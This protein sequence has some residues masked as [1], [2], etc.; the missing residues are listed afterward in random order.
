MR[1]ADNGK[2][3]PKDFFE[4][5]RISL[6][7]H[8]MKSLSEQIDGRMEILSTGGVIISVFFKS[9]LEEPALVFRKVEMMAENSLGMNG[10]NG[11]FI[12]R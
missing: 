1:V 5:N 8:L 2:G 7:M 4:S 6:G 9:I 11:Q 3:L 10:D 12:L